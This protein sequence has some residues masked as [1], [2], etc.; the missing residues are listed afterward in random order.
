MKKYIFNTLLL[1]GCA[2]AF[3]G[4]NDNS[5]NDHLDGFDGN[6]AI[7]DV[8]SIDYT[9]T[10][11]DYSVI[12]GLTDNKALA[13]DTYSTALAA[14][15][16]QHYFN[17]EISARDYAPAFLASTSFPYFSLSDGSAVNLT[18]KTA[19]SLPEEI[20]AMAA[21][22]EYVVSN[23]DYQSVWGSDTDYTA[24][25]TPSHTPASALPSILKK[26]YPDA[27]SG[28]Y[29]IVNY[30]NSSIDPV[31]N[32]S[33]STEPEEFIL[34]N[35]I[36]NVELDK[37]YKISG[38]V[39]AISANGFIL[40]DES[41]S[42]FVFIG[43]TFDASQYKIGTQIV[44]NAVI[45]AYNTGFQVV[46]SSSTFTIAGEQTYTYPTPEIF[47]AS[48]LEAFVKRTEN[49]TAIYGQ[50]TG[51]VIISGSNINIDLGS[52][53]A[54]GGIYYATEEIKSQLVDGNQATVTGYFIAVAGSRYCN[55][56]ATKVE[57]AS[58]SDRRGRMPQRVV[59]V[60]S[61]NEN[62]VYYYNG[63][64]WAPAANTSILN[65]SDY[66][67][68]GQKY[69]NLETPEIYLPTYLKKT[70]PY[71]QVDDSQFVVYKYYDGSGTS[72]RCDQY[73]YNGTEWLLNDGVV[74]ETAR[75]VRTGGKWMYDPN[76]IINLPAGKSQP[77]STLVFQACVDWVYENIDRPLGS[78]SITSGIGYVTKYGNNEY[79]S[80][81][82]AYQGNVDLR[83]SAAVGQYAA[84]YAGMSDEEI[85]DL[86]KKRFCEEVMPGA[87]GSL[88]PNAT[89][90][91]GLTV[92]Y[93]V[94]FAAYD[95]TSTKTYT[96][97][98]EVVGLHEFK[99]IECDW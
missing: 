72:Y 38:V 30:E 20:K 50:I 19:M 51:K 77:M 28:D 24:S 99:F 86:M 55:F 1:G 76:V 14:V 56:V 57:S 18:Y 90:V 47:S 64:S 17:D 36:A 70:F 84:G 81:T 83:P 3:T 41:G 91:D 87:L 71:A 29:A 78:T 6:Q 48:D 8:Q 67:L 65:N 93:T 16:T 34:S 88:Y 12:A 52:S 94:N 89:P 2:I 63:S 13:G 26:A 60:P 82:S 22:Q 73:T 43:N 68:M 15:G 46:G 53:N 59:A 44:A 66:S 69:N 58:A 79:Y 10:A 95:G 97:T 45:G 80:G 61:T 32:Q 31:F 7:T 9:L 5:W 39:T 35:V 21:A 33:G 92:I 23:A 37:T 75:F 96:A 11:A 85:V 4:C 98:F 49:A 40:T 54:M 42:I 25:F 27:K 74:E 62:A